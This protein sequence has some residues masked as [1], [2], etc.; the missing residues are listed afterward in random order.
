MQCSWYKRKMQFS[1]FFVDPFW[2]ALFERPGKTLTWLKGLQVYNGKIENNTITTFMCTNENASS[3]PGTKWLYYHIHRFCSFLMT[4][5][6]V[7]CQAGV[8][9]C[10]CSCVLC[11]FNSV[12]AVWLCHWSLRSPK[13]LLSVIIFSVK[14]FLIIIQFKGKFDNLKEPSINYIIILCVCF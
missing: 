5:Y 9:I 8:W 12:I 10:Q 14:W 6:L 1:T 11:S 3:I 2:L 7:F 13:A 4:C